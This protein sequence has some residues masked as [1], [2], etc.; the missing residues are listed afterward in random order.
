MVSYTR[1][2]LFWYLEMSSIFLFT[3]NRYPIIDI[4][5]ISI[6]SHTSTLARVYNAQ[7]RIMIYESKDIPMPKS[8]KII[9][10]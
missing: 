10:E 5:A 1:N 9:Y 6:Q 3:S 4:K 7:V 2:E 8:K